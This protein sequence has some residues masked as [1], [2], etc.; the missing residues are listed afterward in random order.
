MVLKTIERGDYVM[1]DPRRLKSFARWFRLEEKSFYETTRQ[2]DLKFG[3][4]QG[5]K[6]FKTNYETRM[7]S[8]VRE[9]INYNVEFVGNRDLVLKKIYKEV[10]G[11]IQDF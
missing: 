7:R 11:V 2:Q 4:E 3:S 6:F 10:F 5:Y 8:N 1:E 9:V